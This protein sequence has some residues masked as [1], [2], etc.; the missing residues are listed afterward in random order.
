M[1]VVAAVQ[2]V[3]DMADQPGF[4][5]QMPQIGMRALLPARRSEHGIFEAGADEEV[6][7]RALVLDVLLGSAARDLVKRRLRNEE[8]TALDELAHLPIEEGEQ[9]RADVRAVDIGIGH[10]DDLV[11][12]QLV[13]V[14]LV[15]DAGAERRDQRADLLAR[16]H[17]VHARALDIEDFPAQ[18]QHRLEGT[19]APLLGRAA[20]AVAFHD[21]QLGLGRIAL[22][23]FGQLPGQ[24]GHVEGALLARELARLA[25]RLARG[26][27]FHHLADDHLGFRR[28]FLEP[29]LQ[30]LVDQ[31]LDHRAHLGGNQL[32]LGLRGELRVR[33][34]AGHDRGQ[35]LAAILAGERHPLLLR[36]AA[37]IGIADDLPR[38]RAA[39]CRQMRAAVAL[40]DGVG[41]A[42]DGFV[43]AIV[44]P[45]RTFDRDAFA[46]TL[47]HHRRRNERLLV[48]VDD[49]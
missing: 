9:Q 29:V 48:A 24:R 13:G 47:D 28:V 32:V 23:A 37:L 12:A 33:H 34:L 1:T 35:A 27:G 11:V 26:G 31:V 5:D 25:G 10:D 7:E 15:A 42:V 19:V 6:L 30:R 44:P 3:E 2:P 21:E 17:L 45:Q 36:D 38:Q 22:L 40:R 49:I 8:M 43:V 41:E 46:F 4:L 14:E 16:Q 20:G 39:E 18:R